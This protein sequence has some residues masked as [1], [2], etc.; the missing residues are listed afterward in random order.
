MEWIYVRVVDGLIRMTTMAVVFAPSFVGVIG[1]V[2]VME[3]RP[4]GSSLAGIWVLVV[5]ASAVLLLWFFHG[6]VVVQ[7]ALMKRPGIMTFDEAVFGLVSIVRWFFAQPVAGWHFLLGHDTGG[8]AIGF[9]KS[10]R[11]LVIAGTLVVVLAAMLA[12]FEPLKEGISRTAMMLALLGGNMTL[13][14]ALVRSRPEYCATFGEILSERLRPKVQTDELPDFWTNP[15]RG[16]E[17]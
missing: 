17:T 15:A 11:F 16:D 4:A 3:P 1:A 6:A 8:D 5:M 12:A 13:W 10:Q 2:T 7:M 14:P 9:L